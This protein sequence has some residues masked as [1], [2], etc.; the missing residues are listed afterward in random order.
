MKI[1][2]WVGGYLLMSLIY[3]LTYGIFA[4]TGTYVQFIEAVVYFSYM[5]NCFQIVVQKMG[6]KN[7]TK[8]SIRSRTVNKTVH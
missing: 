7:C 6:Y 3:T 4:G 2:I 5:D 8:R 1:L